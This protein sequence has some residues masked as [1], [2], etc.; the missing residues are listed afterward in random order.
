MNWAFLFF[1]SFVFGILLNYFL[2]L[3]KNKTNYPLIKRLGGV[4]MVVAF[5]ITVIFFSNLELTNQ[6]KGL[7]WGSALIVIFGILDDFLNLSWKIQL[8]FQFLLVWLLI[9]FDFSIDYII[10]PFGGGVFDF[11]SLTLFSAENNLISITG[12][13]V[14]LAFWLIYIINAV[15][16]SDGA[17]GLLAIIGFWGGV[18][19]FWVSLLKEVNQPALAILGV[20]FLGNIIS[21]GILNFHPAKIFAGTS[22]SYFVGFFLAS[23]A[24]MAGTKMATALI[25]LA[26][27]LLDAL[28]VIFQRFLQRKKITE[29]DQNHLHFKLQKMGLKT[30]KLNLIYFIFIALF[31]FW[32]FVLRSKKFKL[33]LLLVEI[34]FIFTFLIYVKIKTEDK[35]FKR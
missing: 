3:I 6:I 12:G 30:E 16:W 13:M 18:S 22:G 1:T 27:P 17:D 7:L 11:Q 31:V 8:V 24:V 20:I 32:A 9:F 35:L 33:W 23:V 4:G 19:I 5:L 25:V 28:W 10:N 15:N 29:K 34:L 21:F 14:I 2:V 26:I